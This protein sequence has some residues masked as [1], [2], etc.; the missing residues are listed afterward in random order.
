MRDKDPLKSLFTGLGILDLFPKERTILSVPY[1]SNA[2][3]VPQ[4]TTYKYLALLREHGFVG[5]DEQSGQYKLGLR[6]FEFDS[7]VKSQIEIDT[8]AVPYL[9]ELPKQGREG[10]GNNPLLINHTPWG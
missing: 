3:G 6:L 4:S 2:L 10:I 8:I 1:I 5:Y 9:R 7:S